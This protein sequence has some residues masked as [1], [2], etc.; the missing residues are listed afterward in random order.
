MHVENNSPSNQK[1]YRID[2]TGRIGESSTATSVILAIRVS[3]LNATVM[4]KVEDSQLGFTSRENAKDSSEVNDRTT[5]K[6]DSL[7]SSQLLNREPL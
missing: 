3:D 5:K 2:D 7:D 4:Y 1:N 6:Y